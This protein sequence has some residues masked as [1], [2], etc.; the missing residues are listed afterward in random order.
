MTNVKHPSFKAFLDSLLTS[1]DIVSKLRSQPADSFTVSRSGILLP[2]YYSITLTY[3]KPLM[4]T[5]SRVGIALSPSP[6]VSSKP[7][8]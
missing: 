8:I 3:W 4:A 2:T 7:V 1:D 5:L 6:T